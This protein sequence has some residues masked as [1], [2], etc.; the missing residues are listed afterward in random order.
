MKC[1][2]LCERANSAEMHQFMRLQIMSGLT[3]GQLSE[4]CFFSHY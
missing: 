4:V 3:Y 1:A 2:E